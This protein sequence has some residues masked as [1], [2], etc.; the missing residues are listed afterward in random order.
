MDEIFEILLT[1]TRRSFAFC[2]CGVCHA[3]RE[4]QHIQDRIYALKEKMGNWF[5][6]VDTKLEAVI[7]LYGSDRERRGDNE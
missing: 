4:C 5:E 7:T 3:C 2:A 1:L 6:D